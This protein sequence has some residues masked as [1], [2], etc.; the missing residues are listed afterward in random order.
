MKD[1][2]DF[3]IKSELIPAIIQDDNT[4]RVLMLAYM[5]EISLKKTLESG[6]TW[7][8]SRSR[9]CLW[10]KGAHSG[11]MQ[12][13]KSIHYDCDDDTLLVAVRQVGVACHTGEYSCFHNKLYEGDTQ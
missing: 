4:G 3:F 10:N 13:V 11:N 1:L 8:Y 9:R 5:N 2:K 12:Y 6:T 7:F